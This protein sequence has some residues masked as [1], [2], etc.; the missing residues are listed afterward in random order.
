M[1]PLVDLLDLDE[2]GNLLDPG[3]GAVVPRD[4]MTAVLEERLH[5]DEGATDIFVYVHGWRT[6]KRRSRDSAGRLFELLT[7]LY[8]RQ[9]ARYPELDGFRPH[10]ICVRWPSFGGYSTVRDRAAAV[11]REGRAGRV[12]AGL[13]GYLNDRRTL[14]D[15]GPD[16]LRNIHGQYLHCVGHSFGGRFLSTA[17]MDTSARLLDGGPDTLSWPWHD[18]NYPW[19]VDSLTVFQMAVPADAF[20]RPPFSALLEL[21]LLNAPIALTFSPRDRALGRWHRLAEG[22]AN[23]VGFRGTTQAAGPVHTTLL[24]PTTVPYEFPDP[25]ARIINV[26]AS[27]HYRST[28]GFAGA[29]SDYFHPESAHLLLSLAA[30]AR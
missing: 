1:R 12:L 26:N 18:K 8:E 5:L 15:R 20:A 27:R 4:D 17:I 30:A 23:A 29:H 6:T 2:R 24:R 22:G 16:I 28:L 3:G 19:T 21:N 13:L 11:S 9:P 10:Y 7:E 14:P 25:P